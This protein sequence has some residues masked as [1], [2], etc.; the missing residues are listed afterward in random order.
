MSARWMR[1]LLCLVFLVP[2]GGCSLGAGNA[3][4]S[5]GGN[6]IALSVLV[7]ERELAGSSA[8]LLNE[9]YVDGISLLELFKKSGV[10]EFSADGTLTEVNR[11]LLGPGMAWNIEMNG[12]KLAS[13]SSTVD[14]GASI[15]MSVRPDTGG[16]TFQP[17]IIMVNGGSE[18]PELTHCHVL[19]FTEDLSVKLL[20]KNSGMVRLA[21]D[22]RT[23]L[24]VM[25]Y[26][27][28]SNEE[29]RLRVNDK[30]L[31]SNGVDMKLK[32]LDMLEIALVLRN[33]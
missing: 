32:P 21:E 18:Q 14:P 31:L 13:L 20:M 28:L 6:G 5:N 10:A 2:A 7:G 16:T 9:A 27:P 12:K 15:V 3:G 11:I 25:D 17:V 29:W 22:N 33:S 1:L 8:R 30:A 24:N 4:S 19:P 26:T 23:L